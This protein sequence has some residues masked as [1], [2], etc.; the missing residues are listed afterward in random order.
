MADKDGLSKVLAAKAKQQE[1]QHQ[2][3]EAFRL[4]I[5]SRGEAEQSSAPSFPAY[6]KMTTKKQ[7]A[8]FLSWIGN[9]C[10]ELLQRQ[11]SREDVGQ[12]SY[13]CLVAGLTENWAQRHTLWPRDFNSV[14]LTDK[15]MLTGLPTYEV[16][17]NTAIT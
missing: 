10:F 3:L 8:Y 15:V 17:P 9:E 16:W 4:L 13:E 12:Q 1:Q 5:S 7:S 2:M 14:K 11:I 6:D